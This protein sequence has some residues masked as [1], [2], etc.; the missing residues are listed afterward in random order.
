LGQEDQLV[1][2]EGHMEDI[3]VN[4][5]E[6]ILILILDK[7]NSVLSH[8][9]ALV[10]L[11]VDTMESIPILVTEGSVHTIKVALEAILSM[12]AVEALASNHS[13]IQQVKMLQEMERTE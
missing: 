9:R 7:T 5:A 3:Q 10:D 4:L 8:F 13:S 1:N 6:E 11:T 12:A 2:L